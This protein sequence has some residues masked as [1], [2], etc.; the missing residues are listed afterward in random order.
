MG[1]DR[2]PPLRSPSTAQR[3]LSEYSARV[4]RVILYW[5]CSYWK[6]GIQADEANSELMFKTRPQPCNFCHHAPI[7]K[8]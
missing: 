6:E 2:P 1:M 5:Q 8:S 3:G 4:F 7:F